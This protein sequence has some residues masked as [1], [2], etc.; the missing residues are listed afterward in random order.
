MT[1]SLEPLNQTIVLPGC[2]LTPTSLV[3]NGEPTDEDLTAIGMSLQR[4]EGCKAW[5]WGDFLLK[6]EE[7]HGEHYSQR[8]AEVTGLEQQTLRRYK[9]VAKFFEPLRRRN[10]L[11]WN[12]HLEAMLA[13]TNSVKEGQE[14]LAKAEEEKLPVSRLRAAIRK[15]KRDPKIDDTTK[16]PEETYSEVISFNRWSRGML[17]KAES[18]S[19]E[20]AA[21]ILADL[22]EAV[23]L[24]DTLKKLAG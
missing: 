17:P 7:R 20:R 11:S 4:I 1:T 19:K 9:M 10:D 21:A 3:F 6:Q 2:T 15:S 16:P 13:N 5:W 18:F 22:Q 14:W 24:L 12:H 8:Y 23:Q